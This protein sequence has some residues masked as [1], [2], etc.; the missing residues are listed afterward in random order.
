MLQ[1]Q[2]QGHAFEPDA[3]Q[4]LADI[5]HPA[6]AHGIL[7]EAD[8]LPLPVLIDT[9]TG[10]GDVDMRVPVLPDKNVRAGLREYASLSLHFLPGI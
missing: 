4:K 3:Q 6:G 2:R 8:F 10:D 5:P 1:G 9:A 7:T